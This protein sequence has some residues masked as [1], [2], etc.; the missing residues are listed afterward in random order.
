MDSVA[1]R[2]LLIPCSGIGKVHGLIAREGV[3]RA[4]EQAFGGEVQTMCLPLLVVGDEEARRLVAQH[5][6]ITVDGCPKL[7]AYKNTELAGGK[8]AR[9]LRVLDVLKEHKGAQPGT[10][11]TLSDEGWKVVDA[12]SSE[13]MG[14]VQALTGSGEVA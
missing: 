14:E 3:L 13:L 11:T 8:I 12:L 7:C 9:S 10:A 2:V 5:P 4:V 1:N 6:V